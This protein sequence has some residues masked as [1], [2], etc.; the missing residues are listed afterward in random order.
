MRTA[1]DCLIKFSLAES[2]GQADALFPLI[3]RNV[4]SQ[5]DEGVVI[6]PVVLE[7]V[8][9]TSLPWTC[10][11]FASTFQFDEEGNQNKR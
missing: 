11:I 7:L 6:S 10:L 1:C 4:T 5:S 2:S 3:K 8:V 9:K